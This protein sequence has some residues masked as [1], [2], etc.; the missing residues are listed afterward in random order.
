M[1]NDIDIYEFEW[2]MVFSGILIV[3]V[4]SIFLILMSF[5]LLQMNSYWRVGD[6][7][8]IPGHADLYTKK[9]DIKKA[10]EY[11]RLR[12]GLVP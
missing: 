4:L 10:N 5:Y 3:F 6:G 9:G 12:E 1:D 11:L 2:W 8:I 7:F